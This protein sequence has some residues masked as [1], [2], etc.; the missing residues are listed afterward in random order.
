MVEYSLVPATN[1]HAV[2]VAGNM[3]KSDAAEVWA[4]HHHSPHSAVLASL[5]GSRNPLIG[6]ADEEPVCIFGHAPASPLSS[7]TSPWLLGT[8]SLPLHSR[9]FLKLSKLYVDELGKHFRLMANYVDERNATSVRW[10]KWL[11][12]KV[13]PAAPFGVEQ[14]PF[15]YFEKRQ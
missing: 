6:L 13:Y 2:R 3:R 1:D 12:F 8:D 5:K 7:S 11:G 14:M 4:S 9:E 10:L 15:H